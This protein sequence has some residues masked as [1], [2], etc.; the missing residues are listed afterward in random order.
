MRSSASTSWPCSER[1]RADAHGP[2]AG[3]TLLELLLVVSILALVAAVAAPLLTAPSDSVRLRSATEQIVA[4]LSLARAGAIARNA[5]AAVVIDAKSRTIH[6]GGRA[7][8]FPPD[9]LVRL[10][11]AESQR[12]SPTRGGF[13]FFADG[14]STGGSILLNLRGREVSLCVD[15]LTGKAG[16]GAEC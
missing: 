13:R 15:W 2:A 14:S 5:E 10:T 8:P 12:E 3:F 7:E 4:A 16:R 9:I 11:I 6:R 1:G